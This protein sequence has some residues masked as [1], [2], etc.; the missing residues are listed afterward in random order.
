MLRIAILALLLMPASLHAQ[1]AIDLHSAEVHNSPADV[2]D[3]P[4]TIHIT[5]LD[6]TPGEHG[7]LAF[8]T[9]PGFPGSW[10]YHIPG[11]GD[12]AFS[13]TQKAQC[14]VPGIDNGCIQYTVWAVAK[15]NGAWHTAGFIQM[16]EWKEST[17][18]PLLAQFRS[19]WAYACDRWA[20]LCSYQPQVG[21]T[22]GFFLTAGNARDN[23]TV[24]SSRERSNVVTIAVPAGDRG[25]FT[26]GTIVPPPIVPPPPPAP[27]DLAPIL[28]RLDRLETIVTALAARPLAPIS[29]SAAIPGIRIP[30][31][32]ELKP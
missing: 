1:D 25:S 12:A 21:D 8:A 22:M 15:I 26:F 7:G 31:T 18:A 24:S 28:A 6:E 23:R 3:W 16:W 2:A 17:G 30:L 20:V 11:W 4:I 5:Q 32:C 29:C 27:G 13:D 19:D 10:N 14:N 9:A